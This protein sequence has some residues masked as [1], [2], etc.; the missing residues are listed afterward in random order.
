MVRKVAQRAAALAYLEETLDS[1]FHCTFPLPGCARRA[2][3]PSS[4]RAPT[5]RRPPAQA[6]E[7]PET[8]HHMRKNRNRQISTRGD[9]EL[10]AGGGRARQ[11]G[12]L[13]GAGGEP[14][15]AG[16]MR[17]SRRLAVQRRR[18]SSLAGD[19][20]A[21]STPRRQGRA[22]RKTYARKV[23]RVSRLKSLVFRKLASETISKPQPSPK[24][25]CS[26]QALSSWL[27]TTPTKGHPHPAN[28]TAKIWKTRILRH[29]QPISFPK[30]R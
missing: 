6:H 12:E 26:H 21:S 28:P 16:A 3:H 15:S 30:A 8:N 22:D 13:R 18:R 27:A 2:A 24:R 29:N 20:C 17:P 11:E 25:Q 19:G 9:D 7:R 4:T 5:A 23:F 10:D 1:R 14:C